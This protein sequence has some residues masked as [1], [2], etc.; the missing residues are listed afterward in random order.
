MKKREASRREMKAVDKSRE[1]V[2]AR[3]NVSFDEFVRALNGR[4]ARLVREE[5]RSKLVF[6]ETQN[7]S[8]WSATAKTTGPRRGRMAPTSTASRTRR[9]ATL[10]IYTQTNTQ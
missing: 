1:A 3:L 2:I 7:P 8:T 5:K 10:H 6:L 9:S 4:E